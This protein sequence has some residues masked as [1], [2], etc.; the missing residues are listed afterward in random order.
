MKYRG[1]RIERG[2]RSWKAIKHSFADTVTW[3]RHDKLI[4]LRDVT[5]L[6]MWPSGQRTRLPCA[7]ERD[8]LSVRCL[9]LSPSTS[10][11]QRIISHNSYA[12]DKYGINP[13]H[14]RGFD[15]VLYKL[16]PLLMPWLPASRCQPRWRESRSRQMW[17]SPLH[18]RWRS[19]CQLARKVP[20]VRP[21]TE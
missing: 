11:Y 14:V 19:V 8:A 4:T 12:Y 6:P 21:G 20:A 17:L 5:K 16:W 7:V 15:G 2:G 10:A 3:Q 9:C 18:R 13:G 1:N